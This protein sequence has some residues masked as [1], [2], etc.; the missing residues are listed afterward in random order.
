M[1]RN[2][3][4]DT[5]ELS[6]KCE[7]CFFT[8]PEQIS[9]R[10]IIEDLIHTAK[11]NQNNCV[12]LAANQISYNKRIVVI[13]IK[14]EFVSFVNPVIQPIRT[15]GVKRWHEGCLSFPGRKRVQKRRFKKI[16]VKYQ[17]ITGEQKMVVLKGFEA[18]IMQHEVDHLN[19]VCI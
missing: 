10:Q 15:D 13:L 6:K 18:A 3:V 17:M 8:E 1:I 4:T 14:D 5:N 11:A 2:I 16:K 9:N 19:G 12:G 7:L